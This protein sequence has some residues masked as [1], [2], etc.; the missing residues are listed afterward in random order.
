MNHLRLLDQLII[1]S[2]FTMVLAYDYFLLPRSNCIFVILCQ[3]S[4]AVVGSELPGRTT[5]GNNNVIGH[6]AVVGVQCQDLKYKVLKFR[7]TSNKCFVLICIC[8]A[9]ILDEHIYVFYYLIS[10]HESFAFSSSNW[11][12]IRCYSLLHGTIYA[13]LFNSNVNSNIC[14]FFSKVW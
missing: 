1:Q 11:D 13:L 5:I 10:C 3:S 2:K 9:Y 12:N 6:H 4:G 7:R 14:W 8:D